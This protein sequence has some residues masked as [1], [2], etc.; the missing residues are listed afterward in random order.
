MVFAAAA[1]GATDAV[2]FTFGLHAAAS[3][4]AFPAGTA[5]AFA[6]AAD[7]AVTFVAV[8]ALVLC[9]RQ[10]TTRAKSASFKDSMASGEVGEGD[11]GAAK[12]VLEGRR[13]AEAV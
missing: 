12:C 10:S 1:F 6:A 13:V 4:P 5:D 2:P 3:A 9:E 11:G 8:D 7:G